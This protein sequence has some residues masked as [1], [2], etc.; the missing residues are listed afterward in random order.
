MESIEYVITFSVFKQPDLSADL[1]I[2]RF[3]SDTQVDYVLQS[4]KISL[5]PFHF[6]MIGKTK[7]PDYFLG[8]LM[9]EIQSL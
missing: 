9:E 7:M 2:I 6:G 1:E 8:Q 3:W 4:G 5:S